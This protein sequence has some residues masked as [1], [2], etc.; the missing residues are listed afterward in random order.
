MPST[1]RWPSGTEADFYNWHSGLSTLKPAKESFTQADLAAACRATGAIPIFDLN[2]LAPDNET[3]PSDQIAMLRAA[4]RLGLPIYYVEVGNELYSNAPGAAQAFPDGASYARTVAIYVDALHKAF[5]GVQVGADAIPF[6]EDKRE[7]SWD[8]ELLAHLRG[9]GSPDAFIVHFYP[10]LYQNP[11]TYADLPSLFENIYRSVSQLSRA[12]Q[13]L[14][15]KP[16]WLTEYNMRGP[17]RVFRLKGIS[18]A[19]HD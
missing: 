1:I 12:I 7:R 6:P 4:K 19:E 5:P 11:F 8:A 14:G 17:Y 13:G 18:P 2:V 16:V 10:G 3:N 9:A 15:G